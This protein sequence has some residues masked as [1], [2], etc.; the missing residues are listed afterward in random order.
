MIITLLG[1]PGSGKGTQGG[2]LSSHLHIP[3]LST[4]DMLRDIAASGSPLGQRISET[5]ARGHYM[6]DG[7]VREM[8]EERIDRQD[9]IGGFILDGFP[10][11]LA[12]SVMLDDI[13][14]ARGRKLDAAIL[15][16][17]SDTTVMTR[18][19]GR[20]AAAEHP[21]ADD[22]PEII[23]ERLRLYRVTMTPILEAYTRQGRLMRQSA[24]GSTDAVLAA[25]IHRAGL[26][27]TLM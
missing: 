21:R 3:H 7:L 27:L 12:Q 18:I 10:R 9:C 2:M 26:S 8:F 16:E 22:A 24:E 4:G 5:L 25:I 11:T 17:V 1:P 6:E 23:P 13:L 19:A 20:A 15:L 14:A